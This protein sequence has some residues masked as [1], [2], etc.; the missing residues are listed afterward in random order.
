MRTF[1]PGDSVTGR[2]FS[3]LAALLIVLSI[4]RLAHANA[5]TDVDQALLAAIRT[6]ASTPPVASRD[7][8]M[9]GIGMYDA[10]NATTGLTYQP[11][12]YTGPAVSGDSS[13]A[14]AYAA[15]YTM[16]ADLFPSEASMFQADATTSIAGLSLAASVQTASTGLGS[17]IAT[18]FFAARANDGSATA[19]TPYTPGTQ[20]GNYQFTKAG[21][22]TVVEP[23]WG[24]VTPFAI[25]SVASVAPPPLWGP[26]TPYPTETAYLA[27]PAYLSGLATVQA[28]GCNG[29]GQTPDQIALAAFWADTNGNALFGSTETPPGHWLDITDTVAASQDLSLLQTARLGAMVGASLADVGIVAWATKNSVNFWRPD[30]AIHA[31]GDTSWEPLWP[32]PLFQSYISGHSSFSLAGAKT[33]ADF[34]WHR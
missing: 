26:G 34:F 21:Q 8:A 28:L 23:S 27:S 3:G 31:T 16:L 19:Q 7:I 5:I 11:Y 24:N 30:T 15:G 22:T 10:V 20:P 14:A 6:N 18:N 17:S 25:T 9:V 29:C 4:P 33:L 13:V 12:S 1:V 2:W 32:D